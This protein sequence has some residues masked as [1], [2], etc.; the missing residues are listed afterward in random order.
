M[1]TSYELRAIRRVILVVLDG[2]RPDAIERYDLK[3]LRRLSELGSASLSA[4][5]VEPSVTTAAMTSLLTGV[6]PT[7]H[8]IQSDHLFIPRSASTLSPMPGVLA[9][10]CYPS[11]GFMGQIPPLFRGLA[12]RIGRQLGFT[13]VHLG[14]NNADEVLA[15]AATTIRTQRRGLIFLHWHDADRAGHSDGWMSKAYGDGCRRLD[16]ALG[17]LTALADV[18][19]DAHT[20][21]IA[22]ADH[23]GGGV[24]PRDHE[25]DHPLDT[26]IPLIIAGGGALP[27]EL[28]AV[29]LLDVPP[30]VLSA[31]GIE[32][33]PSYEGRMLREAFAL[34][35]EHV[36]VA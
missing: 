34:E 23:G 21:L 35:P 1:H 2:L 10:H 13:S 3:H 29:S 16:A 9:N 5:T 32:I 30:T 20:L 15:R 14:G 25:S 4:S 8:G 19:S 28:K 11:S 31:L 26:T 33:P 7:R 12:A 24:A 18:P 6:S 17:A 36:A 22:L 27:V